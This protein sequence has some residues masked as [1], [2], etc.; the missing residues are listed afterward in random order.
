MGAFKR[1]DDTKVP[2][3]MLALLTVAAVAMGAANW[4]ALTASIDTSPVPVE[5]APAPNATTP[6]TPQIDAATEPPANY[7]AML[8]RPLFRA[9]RR[10]SET[11]DAAPE[12]TASTTTEPAPD[13]PGGTQLAGIIREGTSNARALLRSPEQP[14]GDWVQIGHEIGGWR[15]A[16]IDAD[17]VAFEAGGQRRILSLFPT[18]AQ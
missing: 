5:A 16:E 3:W 15:L 8:G 9:T 7:T 11:P 10:P 12:F 6:A 13:L 1:M 2:L 17:N 4:Y 14:N 18:K